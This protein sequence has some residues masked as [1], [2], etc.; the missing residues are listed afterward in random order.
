MSQSPAAKSPAITRLSA[1][2]DP[3]LLANLHRLNQDHAE[4][5][6]SLSLASLER[7]IG[8]AH[9]AATVDD[10]DGLVIVCDQAS[11]YDSPNFL[12]FKARYDRFVY[13]DRIVVSDTRRG[14]GLARQLYDTVFA[15]ARADGHSQVVCE[16]NYDPPNPGSDAFHDRLGFVEVGRAVL[17]DRG[18][19]V[20]YLRLAL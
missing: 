17:A 10:G 15:A 11:D 3:A 5:L 13:V 7:L 14:E 19:G 12:W 8:G 20:R 1:P 6:S 9:L 2:L 16:V 18:K 4:A